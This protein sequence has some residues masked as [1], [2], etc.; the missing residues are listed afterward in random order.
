MIATSFWMARESSSPAHRSRM[1]EKIRQPRSTRSSIPRLFQYM[2]SEQ[3]WEERHAVRRAWCGAHKNAFFRVGCRHDRA[4]AVHRGDALLVGAALMPLYFRSV[5]EWRHTL[6][7][8]GVLFLQRRF[9]RDGVDCAEREALAIAIAHES[10]ALAAGCRSH[11]FPGGRDGR[12]RSLSIP[13]FRSPVVRGSDRRK[14][15]HAV[16]FGMSHANR[17]RQRIQSPW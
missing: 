1:A 7:A 15:R 13:S 8:V 6:D 11:F 12:N 17:R 16:G 10:S 4:W 3:E 14:P 2:R 9:L 5:S